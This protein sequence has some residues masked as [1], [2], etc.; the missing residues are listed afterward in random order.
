MNG[1]CLLQSLH[2]VRAVLS[3]A[4]PEDRDRLIQV[5]DW[6]TSLIEFDLV[7]P[8]ALDRTKALRDALTRVV[9]GASR[10]PRAILDG[11]AEI[12]AQVAEITEPAQSTPA[13][14]EEPILPADTD[15]EL[16]R[17]YIA[18]SLDHVS[19]AESALL[20]IE[21]NP[22]EAEAI[23]RVFRAFHTIKGTSGFLGLALTQELAHRAETILSRARDGEITITGGYADIVL[24]S[25]DALRAMI[26]GLRTTS[27]G[28]RLPVPPSAAQLLARLKEPEKHGICSGEQPAPAPENPTPARRPQP[29]A[30]SSIRVA[31]QRLDHLI[32]TVGELV[33]AHSMVAQD[34]DVNSA[35]LERLFKN[36]MHTSKIVR[37]LQDI[38]MSLRMVPLRGTFQKMARLV[39]DLGRKT[40]KP[41]QYVQA[42]EETE[43]DRNMV[44]RLGDPLVHMV[45]NA[46]DHGLESP[47]ERGRG[48]KP[49]VGTVGLR[50]YHAAGH[51]VIELSDDGR[52]LDKARILAKG[53]ERGLVKSDEHLSDA[54]IYA[55][56]FNAGFSTAAKVT[57]V[58]GRGVGM[59]VVKSSIEA[60]RG[61][62]QIASEKGVG[63]TITVYLPL[64]MAI[65]DAM[66]VRV[67]AER[68]L[69]PTATIEQSFRP[70]PGAVSTVEGRG[71]IVMLRDEIIP[72]VRLAEVFGVPGAITDIF[73]SLLIAVEIEG[74]RCA[75]M[76]DD[77]LGQQQVIV[78]ALGAGIGEIAGISGGTILGDG[79]V[80]LILDISG[81]LDLT[82]TSTGSGPAGTF[83]SARAVA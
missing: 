6:V 59:D 37:E 8:E 26:E 33:V 57:D 5:R 62:I 40:G 9:E 41:V 64:T 14:P 42:G 54:D 7:A 4:N 24:E 58:S 10:D 49:E 30:E 63:T 11:A 48:E 17:E 19:I 72:I 56:I 68:Y 38:S 12:A 67:G 83:T 79:R 47:Q 55:L 31:T 71:E 3:K 21:A 80:G 45:R 70:G 43:I 44:D 27:A 28:E 61:R 2:D 13:P 53:V 25:C 46:I 81:I 32:D 74:R 20:E 15:E 60:L 65:T 29:A 78:K 52:G 50:A 18:E 51:V 73:E 69:L 36:I 22:E 76:A 82:Q 35:R 23:N 34:P 75:L 16:L 77:L 66:L 1:D 39:R